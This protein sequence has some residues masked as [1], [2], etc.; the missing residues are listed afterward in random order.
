MT[1]GFFGGSLH[2]DET[3]LSCDETQPAEVRCAARLRAA[4]REAAEEGGAGRGPELSAVLLPELDALLKA[5]K[6]LSLGEKC[7]TC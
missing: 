4:L 5:L 6:A 2:L 1:Y 7:Q 3:I